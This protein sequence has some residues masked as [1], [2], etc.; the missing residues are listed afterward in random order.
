MIYLDKSC[1]CYWSEPLQPLYMMHVYFLLLSAMRKLW[2]VISPVPLYESKNFLLSF[3]HV[4]T[5]L[6]YG[7]DINKIVTIGRIYK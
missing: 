7:V 5:A 2:V 4:S 3:V 1:V 6:E